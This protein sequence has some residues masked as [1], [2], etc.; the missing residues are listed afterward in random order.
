MNEHTNENLQAFMNKVGLN[1]RPNKDVPISSEFTI[2]RPKKQVK[3]P[4]TSANIGR[5]TA[6]I[7]P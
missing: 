2:S 7:T 1:T 5:A 4:G 3:R 6:V